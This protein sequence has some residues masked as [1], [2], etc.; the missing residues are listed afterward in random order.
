[1]LAICPSPVSNPR[2]R[3][4][5]RRAGYETLELYVLLAP[6]EGS[7]KGRI[8]Y[9]P[10]AWGDRTTYTVHMHLTQHWNE[11]QSGDLLDVEFILGEKPAPK[12]S[13]L[14]VPPETIHQRIVNFIEK[15]DVWTILDL[16]ASEF[17]SDPQS[18]ACFDSCV[19][20]R[21]IELRNQHFKET[22][23]R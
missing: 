11:I 1:M 15:A 8:E 23:G 2:E 10:Y 5:W 14:E 4:C 22:A 13:E 3:A 6:L 9:D 21:A 7:R 17:I 20:H 12:T 16:I 19:V 18:V